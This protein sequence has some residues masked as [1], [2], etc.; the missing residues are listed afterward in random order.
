[1]QATLRA[2]TQ[3]TTQLRHV[4]LEPALP[5]LGPHPVEDCCGLRVAIAMLLKSLEPGRYHATYQQFETIRKL[6]AG[7]SNVYM[8]SVIGSQAMR[9][10]GGDR[11]KHYL[12]YS[13]MQSLWFERFSQGCLRRMGQDV[14]QDWAIT[15]AAMGALM[16]CFDRDWEVAT[17]WEQRN[18][19]AVCAAY[20]VIAFCGSFRGN[21]VFLVDLAGLRKYWRELEGQEHAI[22]PLLGR[23]KGEQ[24]SRYHLVPMAVRTNS[25]LEVKLWID[26]LVRVKEEKGHMQGP[27]FQDGRGVLVSARWLEGKIMDQL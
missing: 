19:I 14:R 21:K 16:Q 12:T 8:A 7:F 11:V 20:S 25:G 4:G 5:A 26:R 17:T 6:R 2:V 23:Y 9:T 3:L 13:P 10:V 15:L 27:A 1:M 24:H 18:E 22:V